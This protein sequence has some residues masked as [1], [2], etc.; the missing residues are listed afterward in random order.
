M[1]K[2]LRESLKKKK[3]AKEPIEKEQ[4]GEINL[5]ELDQGN[6]RPLTFPTLIDNMLNDGLTFEKDHFVIQTGLGNIRYGRSFFV[7]PSGYPRT[8]RIGWLEGFFSG[9][10]LDVS[11]H[12]DPLDRNSA[13][14]SL[15]E[16]IDELDT[17]I[18]SAAKRDD[19]GKLED[20]YQKKADTKDLQQQIKNNVN[21]LYYVSVQATVYAESIEDL[22]EKCVELEGIMGGESIELV[23]A[24][25]RQKEGFLSTL[26]LG[27]NYLEKTNR[28]LDQRSLTAIFPHSSSKLNHTGGMPIGRYG[29]E[30][31]Y[32]NQFD[33]R[34][35]NYSMGIFGESG[36]GKGVFVKQIIGRGPMDGI[37]R[38]I[39]LDVEP[40]YL[41]LTKALGGI[42]IPIRAEKGDAAVNRINPFDIYPEK[43]VIN[44]G[45]ADE[46]ILERI[47]LNEKIK[48]LIEF[49]RVMKESCSLDSKGLTPIE[50]GVLNDILEKLYQDKGITED[51]ES[52]FRQ[53]EAINDTGKII[54]Q[55]HYIE[56]PTISDVYRDLEKERQSGYDELKE[57]CMVVKLFTRDKAFGMFDGQTR[58]QT[59]SGASLDDAPIITFDISKLSANG[60]ERPLAQHVIMTWV[61]NRFIVGNPKAKKRVII[62]EAWMMLKYNAMMEFLKLLSARGRK[63]NTSLTLVS[64]RYEMFSRNEA[65]RDVIAQ[66][67]TVCFLKQSDE[68]I[69]PILDTFKFSYEVGEMIRTAETGDV[70]MKAGKE[71]VAFRSEPTPDEWVYLNTN[72]NIEIPN[73]NKPKKSREDEIYFLE[74]PVE[75]PEEEKVVAG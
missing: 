5:D 29:R 33:K 11:V 31:V 26:P 71:I 40:E 39:I 68:D 42:C 3:S 2:K 67:N 6:N 32:F 21:G 43:E 62:D 28:N 51:P 4:T 49:F 69:E 66:L 52:V 55:R 34:L 44:K 15:Q 48:E 22:N 17:V 35:N 53:A 14:K 47:N 54:W 18:Y 60:I 46:Y 36:A 24:Y 59:E 64:Q 37:N 25:G 56:M 9:D 10:D 75:V 57:L 7:K 13:I 74:T 63:W 23:N 45:E 38:H 73:T 30:Y 50:I 58:I 61:W 8:V 16:K 27:K 12:I 20:A 65:S 19:Q 41:E 72:Q 70:V 1:F